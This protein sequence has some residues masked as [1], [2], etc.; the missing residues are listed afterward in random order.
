MSPV[1]NVFGINFVFD[2]KN[3]LQQKKMSL[4]PND[5]QNKVS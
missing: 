3:T 2:K 1:F 5:N 4:K